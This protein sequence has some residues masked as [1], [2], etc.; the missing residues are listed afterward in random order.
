VNP[1]LLAAA[2]GGLLGAVALLLL[3][4]SRMIRGVAVG[5]AIFVI[6][7]GAENGATEVVWETSAMI[8]SAILGLA[9]IRS[10]AI[11]SGG[12]RFWA[13]AAW[14][15]YLA[16]GI[17]LTGSWSLTWM[18]IYF[19]LA[20]LLAWVVS[21]VDPAEL[22]LIY[23]FIAAAA[24]A[25]VALAIV[26]VTVLPEPIWGYVGG[27]R[28]NPFVNNELVRAQGTF[29]H[30]IPF[31]VFCGFSLIIAWSNP[32]RWSQKWR[33]INISIALAGL[34]LSGTRSA[35]L[36]IALGIL[37]HVALNSSLTRW[38]RSVVLI[39]MVGVVLFNIDIGISRIATELIESG[40]FTH[41]VGGL[42]SLPA[43]MGRPP[44]EVWF[45]TGFGDVTQLYDRHLMQQVYMRTVDN[46]L[47]YAIGTLGIVGL[48]A[49]LALSVVTIVLADRTVRAILVMVFAM[50]FSFDLWTWVNMGAL[51]C[52]FMALPRSDSAGE[53]LVVPRPAL[54]ARRLRTP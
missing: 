31:A 48:I 3:V 6:T 10:R 26:E 54:S 44:G 16:V 11:R 24:A 23:G 33:L 41:R 15:G 35:V 4:P 25:Q 50:Y 46:M 17:L 13:V 22:R 49:L 1:V 19:G 43:L 5:I 37:V 29:G 9:L 27:A 52:M 2:A 30:P 53:E 14:L 32:A 21:T 47:I 34:A 8:A 20:V 28:D 36:S 42:S 40:S 51:V 45:G 39:G 18:V 12:V 7:I 38:L